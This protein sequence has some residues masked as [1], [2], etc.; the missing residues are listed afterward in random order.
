MWCFSLVDR[1]I[2]GNSGKEAE[3]LKPVTPLY[4][5]IMVDKCH[6]TSVQ[7][8]SMYNTKSEP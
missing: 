6:Y 7:I 3:L 2:F 8:R 1:S 5:T 4:D